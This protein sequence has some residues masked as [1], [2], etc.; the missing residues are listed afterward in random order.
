MFLLDTNA[1]S[2]LL[3]EHPKILGRLRAVPEDRPVVTSIISRI[4]ILEGRFASILKAAN[5]EELLLAMERL[6]RDENRLV[7]LDI[8]PVTEAVANQ[9]ELLRANKKLKK[10]GR[11]DL[12]IA[13][14]TLAAGAT[15]VTRN[16]KDFVNVPGLILEN[17]AD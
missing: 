17:W 2:D 14:V 16:T 10:M 3:K 9:F 12:L 4:E 1:L 11:P 6:T 8:L 15:L 5:R 7:T 13:C